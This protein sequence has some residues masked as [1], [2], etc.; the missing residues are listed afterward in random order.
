VVFDF[1]DPL[2]SFDGTLTTIYEGE[3]LASSIIKHIEPVAVEV[4]PSLQEENA[5]LRELRKKDEVHLREAEQAVADMIQ[6]RDRERREAIG[7]EEALAV[8]LREQEEKLEKLKRRPTQIEVVPGVVVNCE[9]GEDTVCISNTDLQR[10]ASIMQNLAQAVEIARE[11]EAASK[12]KEEQVRRE[13]DN[14]IGLIAG[15]SKS[16][17]ADAKSAVKIRAPSTLSHQVR[18]LIEER[19]RLSLEIRRSKVV[20]SKKHEEGSQV[21]ELKC[22]DLQLRYENLSTKFVE[23]A[24]RRN[25]TAKRRSRSTKKD[26]TPDG[27]PKR[28]IMSENTSRTPVTPAETNRSTVCST[29]RTEETPDPSEVDDRAADD[30]Q[31]TP[32]RKIASETLLSAPSLNRPPM[33]SSLQ[34]PRLRSSS[35]GRT[36]TFADAMRRATAKSLPSPGARLRS[37]SC[38]SSSTAFDPPIR[39]QTP[40]TP[41]FTRPSLGNLLRNPSLP[42]SFQDAQSRICKPMAWANIPSW[43]A[44]SGR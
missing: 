11:Q 40:P 32:V 26:E 38:S 34:I 31:R 25:P 33:R 13:M 4:N 10:F 44:N 28:F 7:R 41:Q 21:L 23:L 8:S 35:C 3:D 15:A 16:R 24:H 39:K 9:K 5:R 1:D 29:S 27:T 20:S 36:D 22:K 17:N 19:D 30:I 42:S 12:L 6:S 14:T 37:S 43:P 2:T 18:A